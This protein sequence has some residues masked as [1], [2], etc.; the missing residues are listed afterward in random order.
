MIFMNADANYFDWNNLTELADLDGHIDFAEKLIRKYDWPVDVKLDFIARLDEI[1]RKQ[2]DTNL[3][4]SVIGEF[5]SGKSTFINALLRMDLLAAGVLQG[6]TVASTVIEYGTEYQFELQHQNGA[7][8][9]NCFRR[10]EDLKEQLNAIVSENDEAESLSSVTVQL[11]SS[12]LSAGRFRIIDTP[13][14]D[15]TIQWHEA[16][17]V[18]TLRETSDLSIIL[19]D[20]LRPLPDS[21]CEFVLEHLE[22]VLEQCVFVV[23][24]IDLIPPRERNM[25]LRYVEK[26]AKNRFGIPSPLVLPYASLEVINTFAPELYEGSKYQEDVSV[27]FA[28]E[29]R[30]LQHMALQRATAQAK[31]LISLIDR[32]YESISNQMKQMTSSY[33]KR[34]KLLQRTRQADLS[35]FISEQKSSCSNTYADA[36]QSVRKKL[37][38]DIERIS[39]QARETVLEN[40]DKQ[41][42]TDSLDSYVQNQFHTDCKTQADQM[43]ARISKQLKDQ[44]EVAMVFNRVLTEYEAAFRKQFRQLDCLVPEKKWDV[45]VAPQIPTLNTSKISL[46]SEYTQQTV[47]KENNR[48]LGGAAAGAAAGS[49]IPGLGTLAGAAVGFFLGA[50]FGPDLSEM[51]R[52]T[53]EKLAAPAKQYFDKA[54]DALKAQ[55]DKYIHQTGE[56][57]NVEIDRY[58]TAYQKTVDQWIAEEK[59]KRKELETQVQ[60]IREDMHQI[61]IRR[62]GLDS[63]RRQMAT[64]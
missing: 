25:L 63:V 29:A 56:R 42:T 59:A 32:I 35:E 26:A 12:A 6:T 7:K 51:K 62:Q 47:K 46:A 2:Q 49:I 61:D 20:A 38:L 9:T 45:I 54:A 34:L 31:K 41:P 17:T 19:V 33:E 3:N 5:S 53:K 50:M 1:R 22:P 11:P 37:F 15:A 57:I 39:K 18:R 10:F 36:V 43:C 60:D 24:K 40:V 58:L 4:L 44:G 64:Q 16:V 8:Q 55:V 30:I 52:Q 21:L 48:M 13:G 28:S 23:T 27:S 14:L